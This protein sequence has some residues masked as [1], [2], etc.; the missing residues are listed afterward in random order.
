MQN[1]QTRQS[2]EKQLKQKGKLL[3][4][5]EFANLND[6]C[7]D[8]INKL[9]NIFTYRELAI[10]DKQRRKFSSLRNYAFKFQ[11]CLQILCL[12]RMGTQ[13]RQVISGKLVVISS[14]FILLKYAYLG[15]AGFEIE[16]AKKRNS[17]NSSS[18]DDNADEEEEEEEVEDPT[19]WMAK[20]F[21]TREKTVRKGC[22]AI[23]IPDEIFKL[24]EYFQ[25]T[26]REHLKPKPEIESLWISFKNG[27][28]QQGYQMS[29]AIKNQIAEFL[30]GKQIT[31][32]DLRRSMP[33]II[34]KLKF[35]GNE[36]NTEALLAKF[37]KLVNTS[38]RMLQQHYIR[39]QDLNAQ[40]KLITT[41]NTNLTNTENTIR[42]LENTNQLMEINY[43]LDTFMQDRN[44]DLQTVFI[45]ENR[46]PE[47]HAEGSIELLPIPVFGLELLGM[48][49]TQQRGDMNASSAFEDYSSSLNEIQI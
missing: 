43:R 47:E 2:D 1:Q 16:K 35:A 42:L 17:D 46:N 21:P 3:N 22:R 33:T 13:R 19:E 20:L 41:L 48:T 8:M 31:P 23:P 7:L 15:M 28:V 44:E 39:Y 32:L 9:I 40:A 27:T 6:K 29:I 5:K 25:K 24:L 38:E 26:I 18:G 14:R 36:S 30:P 49:R 34:Q 4:E 45:M 10:T 12:I 37:A 11:T